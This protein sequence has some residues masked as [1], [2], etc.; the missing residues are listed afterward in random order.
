MTYQ[1]S[2]GECGLQPLICD[3]CNGINDLREAG[4]RCED[5][6]WAETGGAKRLYEWRRNF[7]N[8]R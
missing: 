7:A 5:L 8:E 3:K 1:K 6:V 4:R 2:Q